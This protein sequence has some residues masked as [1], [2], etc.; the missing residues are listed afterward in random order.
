[1]FTPHMYRFI[2]AYGR[3][4]GW[5]HG[6]VSNQQYWASR[7]HAPLD[8]VCV[9]QGDESDTFIRMGDMIPARQRELNECV[10]G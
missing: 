3:M 8:T 4:N 2:R 10:A 5:T 9:W 6:E 1:M 7:G